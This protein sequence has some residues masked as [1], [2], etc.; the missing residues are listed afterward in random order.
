AEMFVPS[1]AQTGE[2]GRVR[3]FA[4]GPG[5]G[6]LACSYP[7]SV[8]PGGTSGDEE[9][10]E[11]EVWISGF[12]GI[13]HP[14]VSGDVVFQSALED[15]SGINL[16][17]YPGTQ[18]AL[19]IDDTPVD[20]AEYFTYEP[21]SSTSGRIIYPL[22]EL[23]PGDHTLR[24]R[25]SDNVTNISWEE[26]TF[27]LTDNST[28]VIDQFFVYPTPASTVMSFNWIQSMDGSVSLSIYSV[29]GRL[30]RTFGNLQGE[31]GYNQYHWNLTDGDGDTVA[32]GNY[33]YVVSSGDSEITGIAT[34]VR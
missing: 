21:G 29:S 18:L 31:T 6:S 32:S 24:L 26:M 22:P 28:P 10:P 4:P 33:I 1:F 30:V 7:L 11:I 13:E 9:G 34:V 27:Q 19:Y 5:G 20:V 3:Y 2:R 12:R 25:A 14:S 23:Q 15:S 16:L 17:P 8:E